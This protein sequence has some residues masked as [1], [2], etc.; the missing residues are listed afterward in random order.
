MAKKETKLTALIN[1]KIFTKFK[2]QTVI[3]G[4]S[5]KETIERLITVYLLEKGAIEQADLPDKKDSDISE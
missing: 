2:I 1:E 5:I 3:D 4:S